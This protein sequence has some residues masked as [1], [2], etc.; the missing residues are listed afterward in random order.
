MTNRYVTIKLSN[1]WKRPGSLYDGRAIRYNGN[2]LGR[3]VTITVYT[4]PD[5]KSKRHEN[6]SG[7][8][9]TKYKFAQSCTLFIFA[10]NKKHNM[11]HRM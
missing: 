10:R 8:V 11:Y 7:K 4:I 6:L 2:R 3:Y 9:E 1:K 5:R